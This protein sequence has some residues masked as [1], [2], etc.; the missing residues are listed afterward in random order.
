MRMGTGTI[1]Q[2]TSRRVLCVVLA[3]GILPLVE[4]DHDGDDEHEHEKQ[5]AVMI[6]RRQ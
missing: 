4:A 3:D 6:H 1:V 2:A 5:I